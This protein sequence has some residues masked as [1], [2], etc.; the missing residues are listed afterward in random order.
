MLRLDHLNEEEK[1][2]VIRL[3]TNYAER[4]QLPGEP[5]GATNVLKHR[6]PTTNDQPINVKQYRYPPV[7]KEEIQQQV[8]ELLEKDVIEPSS[9]PYN[10]PL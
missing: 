6:I 5:L 3:V 1:A 2:N 4:F 9:S 10:S 7:H 8:G